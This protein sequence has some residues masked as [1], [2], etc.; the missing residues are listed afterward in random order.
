MD[1]AFANSDLVLFE[2][3][4]KEELENYYAQI[5]QVYQGSINYEDF[6]DK[7]LCEV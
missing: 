6:L 4:N 3:Q 1:P 2:E 7:V 5:N